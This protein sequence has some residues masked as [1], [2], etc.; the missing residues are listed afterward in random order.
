MRKHDAS[1]LEKELSDKIGSTSGTEPSRYLLNG[2]STQKHESCYISHPVCTDSLRFVN[3]ST[4][5]QTRDD[6]TTICADSSRIT[7]PT[8]V[9]LSTQTDPSSFASMSEHLPNSYI[10]G[11][12]SSEQ[13]ERLKSQIKA[14][15][16]AVTSLEDDL[17][18]KDRHLKKLRLTLKEVSFSILMQQLRNFFQGHN[19][20]H[21]FL[22][23][24][25][26]PD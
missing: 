1:S 26:F 25:Y 15:S 7:N 6:Q 5:V 17:I 23:L 19:H 9:S 2:E 3:H 12:C 21:L 8:T 11:S 18:H 14:E 13:V 24:P 22:K 10:L 20:H 4:L 16:V